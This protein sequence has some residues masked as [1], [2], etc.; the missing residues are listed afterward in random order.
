MNKRLYLIN[1]LRKSPILTKLLTSR[2]LREGFKD[3]GYPKKNLGTVLFCI[4]QDGYPKRAFQDYANDIKIIISTSLNFAQIKK[5]APKTPK[6]QFLESVQPAPKK[7][8][9][10]LKN[11]ST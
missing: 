11:S 10:Y 6:L 8:W 2:S 5:N 1:E 9:M 4:S 3:T 7:D